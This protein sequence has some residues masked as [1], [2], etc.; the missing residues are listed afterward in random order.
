M[1]GTSVSYDTTS[2]QSLI[3]NLSDTSKYAKNTDTLTYIETQTAAKL[4]VAYSDTGSKVPSYYTT[5]GQL[6]STYLPYFNGT[7]LLNTGI[8]YN[9]GKV[10]IGTVSPTIGALQVTGGSSFTN[11]PAN[12]SAFGTINSTVGW[13]GT[14]FLFS[15]AANDGFGMVYAGGIAYFGKVTNTTQSPKFTIDN[16]NS[17]ITVGN[18]YAGTASPTNG[19]IIQ[20]NVSIG[21]TTTDSTLRVAGSGNF[22]TNLKVGGRFNLAGAVAT[23]N[24]DT[25]EA[26]GVPAISDTVEYTGL[27]AAVSQRNFNYT[28]HAGFYEVDGCL[29]VTT[30]VPTGAITVNIVY[31]DALGA[32][33]QTPILAFVAT[34]TGRTYFHIP[35]RTVSGWVAWSTTLV[36]APTYN[37]S[38][39]CKRI[40]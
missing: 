40:Y 9:G 19:A 7:S 23:V 17:G 24:L 16:T 37:I 31:T 10:G 36:A 27:T 11:I 38:L 30:G 4:K 5:L 25:T 33:T 26:G 13:I 20:G 32:T 28:N 8:M 6:S 18:N 3:S 35:V 39:A 2:Y 21:S 15:A 14:G 34:G 29:V 22:T 1:S 12:T